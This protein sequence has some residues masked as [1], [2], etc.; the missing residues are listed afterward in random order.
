MN[1]EQ[2]RV[3]NELPMA[4]SCRRIDFD[5]ASISTLRS[6]PPQYVLCVM[7]KKPYMNMDV[8]LLPLVYITRPEYWGI[9][10]V[11]CLHNIGL[12]A[13]TSYM[14]SIQL[15]GIIGSKGVEV[16]GATTTK[17]FDVPVQSVFLPLAIFKRWVHAHEEDMEGVEVYRPTTFRFP[18]S[19]PRPGFEIMEDGAFIEYVPAPDDGGVVRGGTG[20]WE[21]EVSDLIRVN[22]DG[23]EPRS[24]TLT[25]VAIEED[26]L[27][28]RRE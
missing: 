27:R 1:Q 8:D 15:S 10:V 3:Y 6:Y 13:E 19:H 23:V 2:L 11:G 26:I 16:L 20:H 12:P 7:G 28:V 22:F 9:E 14:V 21:A 24:F 5:E 25:I 17:Q 18:P 4:E